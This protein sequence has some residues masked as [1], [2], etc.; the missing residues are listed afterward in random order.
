[1]PLNI[2]YKL[3]KNLDTTSSTLSN[4]AGFPMSK[5]TR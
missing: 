5:Q 1:M 2:E 3:N 4:D